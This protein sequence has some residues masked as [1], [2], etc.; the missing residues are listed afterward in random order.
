[1]SS[2]RTASGKP[3][4]VPVE[5][6]DAEVGVVFIGHLAAQQSRSAEIDT[7]ENGWQQISVGGSG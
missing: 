1:M 6:S 7:S 5:A 3:V 2:R 4:V